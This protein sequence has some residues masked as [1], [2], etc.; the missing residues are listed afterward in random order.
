LSEALQILF[1]LWKRMRGWQSPCAHRIADT[2]AKS[3][4]LPSRRPRTEQDKMI[5]RGRL[6]TVSKH[7]LPPWIVS[8][9]A[10]YTQLYSMLSSTY[11]SSVIVAMI[12][13]SLEERLGNFRVRRCFDDTEVQH[14]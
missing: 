9:V 1:L 4:L 6:L 11:I 12:S 7:T 14:R 3:N 8:N 13:A 10:Y 2:I 5:L